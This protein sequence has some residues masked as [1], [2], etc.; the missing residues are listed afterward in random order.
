MIRRKIALIYFLVLV[1]FGGGI[2][3]ALRA[4][5]QLEAPRQ[6]APAALHPE[7]FNLNPAPNL[8]L[9]LPTSLKTSAKALRDNLHEPLSQ[10]L[11][12]LIFIVLL[13]RIFGALAGRV[14]QPHVI[15]EMVAGL[16]ERKSGVGG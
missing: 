4:G 14:G 9:H 13:A 12:Q 5:R 11:V 15:G 2:C 10:L 3:A 6:I 8:S 1:V 16:G 7:N